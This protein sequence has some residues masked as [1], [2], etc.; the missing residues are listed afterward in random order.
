MSCVCETLC[1]RQQLS[2][3][4]CHFLHKCHWMG[5]ISVC[6][7]W[8]F[9]LFSWFKIM[10]KVEVDNRQTNKQTNN[11]YWSFYLS[12]YKFKDMLQTINNIWN[13][14]NCQSRKLT[15]WIKCMNIIDWVHKRYFKNWHYL[16]YFT[17]QILDKGIR[18]SWSMCWTY[19]Y[20]LEQPHN[21]IGA[22]PAKI[23]HL[24]MYCVYDVNGILDNTS[25]LPSMFR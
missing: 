16:F 12:G 20:K 2:P 25:S 13:V 6:Q 21:R 11:I 5:F 23:K 24:Y 15:E 9:F 1:Y 18:W 17:G 4:N 19:Q 8:S 10:A 14:R 3:K 22:A 7:S